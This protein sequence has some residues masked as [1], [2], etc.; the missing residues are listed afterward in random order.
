MLVAIVATAAIGAPVLQNLIEKNRFIGTWKNSWVDGYNETRTT[1]I[2]FNSDGTYGWDFGL[3]WD[4]KDGKLLMPAQSSGNNV[5]NYTFSNNDNTLTLVSVLY[6]N[7]RILSRV[8]YE[9]EVSDSIIIDE[10]Q[11]QNASR[12]PND[13]KE[14]VLEGDIL[15]LFVRYGGGCEEHDFALIGLGDWMNTNPVTTHMMLSHNAH[16]DMCKV[17]CGID[18][19]YDLSPLKDAWQQNFNKDSGTIIINIVGFEEPITYEF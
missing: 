14:F 12:D 2:N 8:V 1:Y 3:K 6:N 19:F 7:T 10:Y 9:N 15:R 5:F 16:G 13:I 11:Y 4:I 18:L 17:Y